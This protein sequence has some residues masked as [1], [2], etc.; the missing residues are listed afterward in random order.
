MAG[1]RTFGARDARPARANAAAV[2][3]PLTR[4]ARAPLVF[5]EPAACRCRGA[6]ARSAPAHRGAPA[7]GGA[8]AKWQWPR[9]APAR[10][11]VLRSVLQA[12]LRKTRPRQLYWVSYLQSGH[13]TRGPAPVND[14]PAKTSNGRKAPGQCPASVL[15]SVGVGRGGSYVA[16]F[17]SRVARRCCCCSRT[18]RQAKEP[19]RAKRKRNACSCGASSGSALRWRGFTTGAPSCQARKFHVP[20]HSLPLREK[21]HSGTTPPSC[22]EYAPSGCDTWATPARL[23]RSRRG[24]SLPAASTENTMHR[25][26]PQLLPC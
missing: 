4:T 10:R 6:D 23:P 17:L 21:C 14:E 19:R 9:P 12:W 22:S 1:S 25:P 11:R 26:L 16:A 3:R 7:P 8:T 24:V 18:A 13:A 20:N 2:P 5:P 15:R